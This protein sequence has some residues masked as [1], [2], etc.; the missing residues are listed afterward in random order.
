MNIRQW[1]THPGASL[2][3]LGIPLQKLD[4][5]RWLL[6]STMVAL[7][8]V[9]AVVSTM[10]TLWFGLPR[11]N[12]SSGAKTTTQPETATLDVTDGYPMEAISASGYLEPK[13]EVIQMSAP[14][15]R[16][17][18]RVEQL[19]V[20]RGDRVQSG[21]VVA[22]L[23]SRDRLA[24]AVNLAQQ[25]VSIARANVAQVKAGAKSGSINAQAATTERLAAELQGQISTQEATIDSLQA[26]LRG[27]QNTQAET[28]ERLNAELITAEKECRRYQSLHAD[29]AVSTSLYESVCLEATAVGEQ[30]QE[31]NARLVQTVDTLTKD[32]GEAKANLNRTV[33]TLEQQIVESDA[34]LGA[35]AEVRTVD[36]TLAEAEL[37]R[38]IAAVEEAQTHL[39]LAYV[40][41]PQ[42]GQILKIQTWPGEIIGRDGILELGATDQMYAIAEVYE[43][44]IHQV[45]VGQTATITSDGFPGTLQ[46]VVEDLGIQIAKRD[47]LGTDPAADADARVVEVKIRLQESQRVSGL[48]NLEI[49]AVIDVSG[50]NP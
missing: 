46:G 2:T 9:T 17:G 28:I 3:E 22:I 31:A 23:D 26:R 24:A 27:E 16:E 50:A 6:A 33:T 30:L 1:I 39:D 13:G 42:A 10:V 15:F 5:N 47:V 7:S 38:A 34:R 8:V 40:K 12:E 25:Q 29:G 11:S 45:R 20:K 43:T 44:D 4:A 19:L 49:H 14:A 21:D 48:T 32:I 41:A 35:I 37:S 18:A 36:V